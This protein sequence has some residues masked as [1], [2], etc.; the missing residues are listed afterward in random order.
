[1]L[2]LPVPSVAQQVPA[3]P[4]GFVNDYA[5]MLT[6]GEESRLEQKLRTY[7][8]T[9]SNV[10]VIAT[11]ESL[12]GYPIDDY[13]LKM[14][15]SWN[16]WT[17]D[18]FNGVLVLISKNDRRMRIEVG[19]GLEGALPDALAGRIT[20]RIMSPAFKK[21]DFYRGLDRATDAIMLA[22]AGEYEAVE[23]ATNQS[24]EGL[25]SYIIFALFVA[26]VLWGIFGKKKSG[27]KGGGRGKGR[28]RRNRSHTLHS[29]G[30][31]IGG[32]G[33]GSGGSSGGGGFG[34]FSGGGGFG[35]GG[36]GASG[37]W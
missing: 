21:G 26:I 1:M 32:G 33:F 14:A 30:I 3:N 22:A 31:I 35:F 9:T 25:P 15:E 34:G 10:V 2:W 37:S 13:A 12:D 4:Q 11:V 8:D 27:G 6:S 18:R 24:E 19:Y 7:R 36:G 17:G 5:N 23:Q 29:G 28:R 20:D 16:M